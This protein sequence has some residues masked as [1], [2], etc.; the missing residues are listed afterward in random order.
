MLKDMP[1]SMQTK[2]KKKNNKYMMDASIETGPLAIHYLCRAITRTPNKMF[3]F[4][5]AAATFLIQ[6]IK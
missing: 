3:L 6:T 2:K 5:V 1:R 4:S